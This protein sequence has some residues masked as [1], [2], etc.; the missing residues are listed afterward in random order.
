M[1]VPFKILSRKKIEVIYDSLKLNGLA[2]MRNTIKKHDV[3][4]HGKHCLPQLKNKGG[5]KRKIKKC[6]SVTKINNLGYRKCSL[7][8]MVEAESR[9]QI[10]K[11]IYLHL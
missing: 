3:I 1:S 8:I 6:S 7:K 2:E 11:E 5:E 4:S 10:L 9:C